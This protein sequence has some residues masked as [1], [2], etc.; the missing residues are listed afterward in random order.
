MTGYGKVIQMDRKRPRRATLDLPSLEPM[1]LPGAK[2]LQMMAILGSLTAGALQRRQPKARSGGLS[3]AQLVGRTTLG[4]LS[5]DVSSGG[6]QGGKDIGWSSG[7]SS[8]SSS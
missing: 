7:A 6:W 3:T 2:S 5:W 4:R 1:V 8:W